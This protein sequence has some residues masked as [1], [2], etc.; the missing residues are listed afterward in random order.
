M[1]CETNLEKRK[2]KILI[3]AGCL[4]S[5]AKMIRI[6]KIYREIAILICRVWMEEKNWTCRIIK[7]AF[8]I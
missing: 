6:K 4:D 2:R 1:H 7:I 3:T 8:A 5:F